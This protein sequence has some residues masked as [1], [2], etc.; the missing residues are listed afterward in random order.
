MKGSNSS[1][2]DRIKAFNKHLRDQSTD[3]RKKDSRIITWT[4]DT[5]LSSG[6]EGKAIVFIIPTKGCYWAR[7]SSGGCTVCGYINDSLDHKPVNL[8]KEFTAAWN[9]KINKEQDITAVKIFNSGSFLDSS[10]LSWEDGAGI[11]DFISKHDNVNEI[12]IESRPEFILKNPR[13]L[14]KIREITGSI[15]FGI[16][17][18]LESSNDYI[19]NTY[20]N[21]KIAI[22]DYFTAVEKLKE[23]DIFTKTYVLLK[24]PFLS[25]IEAIHDSKRTIID[26]IKAGSKMISLNP[27]NIHSGT[28]TDWLWKRG[29]YR[30]PWL[31]SVVEVLKSVQDSR[32]NAIIQC[33]PVGAGKIRGSSN[34]KKCNSAVLSEISTASRKQEFSRLNTLDCE[35]KEK[36]RNDLHI[37]DMGIPIAVKW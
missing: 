27:C 36:W 22:A 30:P 8:L 26:A 9:E 31:W 1:G 25:E 14:D 32:N 24:P 20:I 21:K 16:G 2:K 7:A 28:L 12:T 23:R 4:E 37:D 13:R 15:R 29:L 35:C 11:L 5:I 18:G 3:R 33:E 34:C 19:R 10:E 6:K 17:I